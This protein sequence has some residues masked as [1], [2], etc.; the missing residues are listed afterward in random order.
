MSRRLELVWS[1]ELRLLLKLK[2]CLL[3]LLLILAF[4]KQVRNVV[5]KGLDLDAK[6]AHFMD[7]L[8]DSLVFLHLKVFDEETLRLEG[9]FATR[10]SLRAVKA[11]DR[12]LIV[13][14]SSRRR[15]HLAI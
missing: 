8:S 7:L 1:E 13:L 11:V 3:L 10:G 4:Y 2:L 5:L 14:F 9:F 6:E 15:S 12:S